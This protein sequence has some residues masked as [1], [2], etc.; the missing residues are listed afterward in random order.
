[1][2]SFKFYSY[3]SI[4]STVGIV[5]NA[6]QQ[7]TTFFHIVVFLTSSK[8]NLLI[9]FNCLL[10]GLINVGNLLVWIF[11]SEIR[12]IESKYI[13]DKSQKKIFHFLLLTLILRATFDIYKFI[14]LAILFFFWVLHWLVYKRSDYLISR[15]SR[16]KLE[17]FKL[18]VLYVALASINFTISFIFYNKFSLAG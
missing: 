13:V 14:S 9:F 2:L 8:I 18:M 17:H 16:G 1:M 11:F 7:Y 6:I 5:V 15:G 4:L 10:V 3:V 12:P